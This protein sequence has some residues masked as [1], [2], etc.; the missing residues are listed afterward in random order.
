M[1]VYNY[2]VDVYNF[3]FLTSKHVEPVK[4]LVDFDGKQLL[5]L[6]SRKQKAR[7]SAHEVLSAANIKHF[8]ASERYPN[9]SS[10]SAFHYYIRT[11]YLNKR[12]CYST[13]LELK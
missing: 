4:L 6:V 10:I 2:P 13:I 11:L 7:A 12:S 5:P 9:P 1:R 3:T 8:I